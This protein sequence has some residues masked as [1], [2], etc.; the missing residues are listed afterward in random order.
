VTQPEIEQIFFRKPLIVAPD[1]KHSST[2]LR[3]HV[4]GRTD[5]NRWLQVTFTLRDGETSIR[6]ISARPMHRKERPIHEKALK[7]NS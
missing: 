3:Y 1:L 4:L 6:P 5:E 2:E 7:A